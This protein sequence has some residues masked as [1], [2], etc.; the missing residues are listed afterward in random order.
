MARN[1]QGIFK[2]ISSKALEFIGLV[3]DEDPAD[4]Y[5][6]EYED[7]P[8]RGQSFNSKR[9]FRAQE[10]QPMNNNRRE[11]NYGNT[12]Q[13]YRPSETRGNQQRR[14]VGSYASGRNPSRFDTPSRSSRFDESEP[15]REEAPVTR[16]HK[17][18]GSRQRTVMY[19]IHS[20]KDCCDVIDNLLQ[21][22][23]VLLNM[24]GLDSTTMQR[25]VDTLSG[26][27]F[28]LHA[29]IKKISE[30]TYLV[31]PVNVEVDEAYTDRRN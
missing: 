7:T 12:R 31:A 14:T 19:T 22:N 15:R 18:G 27:V 6:D 20:L 9:E 8:S 5:T 24:E 25:S 2:R 11:S 28:A 10:R 23:T 4:T 13:N 17:R 26:A 3:D 21:N 29:T 30:G 16:E 1:K